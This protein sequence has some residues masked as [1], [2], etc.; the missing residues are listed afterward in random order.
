[1]C[2]KEQTKKNCCKHYDY[3]KHFKNVD[4][5]IEHAVVENGAKEYLKEYEKKEQEKHCCHKHGRSY[6]KKYEK[7]PLSFKNLVADGNGVSK[8]EMP[9]GLTLKIYFNEG[10]LIEYIKIG[11][12]YPEYTSSNYIDE[13]FPNIFDDLKKMERMANMIFLNEVIRKAEKL[14][15]EDMKYKR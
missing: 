13:F 12:T 10:G 3:T 5:T 2:K 1:M 11:D 14:R 4:K 9:N 15:P 8:L 7:K 6:G